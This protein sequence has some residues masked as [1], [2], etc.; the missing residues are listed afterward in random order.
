MSDT[1][2]EEKKKGLLSQLGSIAGSLFLIA[3][4]SYGSFC[5]AEPALRYYFNRF[6]ALEK[7]SVAVDE[8]SSLSSARFFT[9]PYLPKV[10]PF[11]AFGSF[12]LHGPSSAGEVAYSYE[13]EANGEK[14]TVSSDY[15]GTSINT[16]RSGDNS[17]RIEC[18]NGYIRKITHQSKMPDGR[19]RHVTI[20]VDKDKEDLSAEMVIFSKNSASGNN[21]ND[22]TVSC[23][24]F[25]S[26]EQITVLEILANGNALA[27]KE[28]LNKI[29]PDP[30]G[31][32][33]KGFFVPPIIEV[34]RFQKT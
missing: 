33:G 23:E 6:Y 32:K 29:A 2:K 30:R 25:L 17:V 20:S 8:S 28:A 9:E 7:N 13:E 1:D 24:S 18:E 16:L 22:F 27:V 34:P 4:S 15:D 31:S 19:D 10:D 26:P 11:S 12:K 14:L 5:F 21:S 3:S